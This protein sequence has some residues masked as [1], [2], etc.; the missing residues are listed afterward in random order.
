MSAP[1]ASQA[2]AP[3]ASKKKKPAES[4]EFQRS[5][6]T[7]LVGMG[8]LTMSMEMAGHTE[9]LSNVGAA[10]TQQGAT[11]AIRP[12]DA[13]NPSRRFMPR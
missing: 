13:I 12:E 4:G 7:D 2:K 8:L 10:P 1:K 9:A 5:L 11:P 6:V 3:P